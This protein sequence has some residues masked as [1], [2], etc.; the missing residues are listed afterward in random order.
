MRIEE[1]LDCCARQQRAI[2]AQDEQGSGTIHALQQWARLIDR[3]A[4]AE[5]RRLRDELDFAARCEVLAN[6]FLLMTHHQNHA[7][8]TRTNN[9]ID[10]P[11]D[12]R[13]SKGRMH[14]LRQVTVHAR[15]LAGR[16]NHGGGRLKTMGGIVWHDCWGSVLR[17]A[18]DCSAIR[19]AR[20]RAA[21]EQSNWPTLI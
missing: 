17:D 20:I 9:S 19:G 11:L 7:P 13:L 12:E 3:M 10:D 14:D 5:L 2:S 4:R 21:R 18:A 1:T 16:E 6:H 8:R 15:S